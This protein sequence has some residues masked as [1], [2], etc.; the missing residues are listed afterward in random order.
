MAN[1]PVTGTIELDGKPYLINIE[2]WRGKDIVDFS[3]PASVPGTGTIYSDLGLYQPIAML[4]FSHGIGFVWH[5]DESGYLNTEGYID[6]RHS[7]LVTLYTQETQKTG[8]LAMQREGGV[9]FG[10]YIYF[11][12]TGGVERWSSGSGFETVNF[13]SVTVDTA[14]EAKVTASATTTAS[15][16]VGA[17]GSNR[18]LVVLIAMETTQTVST[19]TYGGVS[20]TE[21][22]SISST[23]KVCAYR[24]LAPATGANTLA[25]TLG[26]S[27]DWEYCV[28]SLLNVDQVSPTG[29]ASKNTASAQ[30]SSSITP[31]AVEGNLVLDIL[32]KVGAS[33]D[34]LTIG[35]LQTQRMLQSDSNATATQGAASTEPWSTGTTVTMS[36]TWT[37]ARDVRHMGFAVNQ[38]THLVAVNTMFSTGGYLFMCP[39]GERIKKSS[40]GG[41]TASGWSDAGVNSRSADYKWMAMHGGYV[42]AGK[43]SKSIVYYDSSETLASLCGDPADDTT[44]VYAGATSVSTIQGLSYNNYFF[45]SRQDGIWQMDQ[46]TTPYTMKPVLP[47]TDEVSS[48]NLRCMK[49]SNSYLYFSVRDRLYRW[50]GSA[51]TDI[52]PSRLT[53]DWPFVMYGQFDNFVSFGK[54]LFFTARTSAT[55]YTESIICWDGVGYHKLCSPITTGVGSITFMTYDTTNNYLW[56]GTTDGSTHSIFEIP[57][58]ERSEYAYALFPITGTNALTSSRVDCG[59]RRVTKSAPFLLITAQNLTTARYIRVYYNVDDTGWIQWADVKNDGLTQLDYP[60]GQ[61][62]FEAE[63]FL[64]LKF[65][66]VT[67]SSSQS[68]ILEGAI[69]MVMLRPDVHWGYT[70]DIQASRGMLYGGFAERRSAA[71][72]KDDVR[73]VRNS[74]SPVKL[75]SPFGEVIYGYISSV[76][77]TPVEYNEEGGIS[78]GKAEIEMVLRC[79]FVESLEVGSSEEG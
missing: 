16:T 36:W 26:G 10:N 23:S 31:A 21:I 28:I 52:T 32:Y 73:G 1:P 37:N 44:E 54:W 19:I 30:T 78:A 56:Y 63:S 75:V 5:T 25:I 42:F 27:T 46:T 22:D 77:E 45:A 51:L 64:Q 71:D 50:N 68:P 15:F 7:N 79:S 53:A 29:V 67:D 4:D 59:F 11:W 40:T 8:G 49:V 69:L 72:I 2:S 74:K 35:A 20:M 38:S 70:F 12:G 62:S 3:P 14:A 66:L 18:M 55:T 60:G 61:M 17:D 65:Q 47:F 58:N 57:F 76:S 24:L 9:T 43:D 34:T 41:I 13:K 48:Y 6:T 39:D 33:T